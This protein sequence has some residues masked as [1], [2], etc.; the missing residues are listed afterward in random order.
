MVLAGAARDRWAGAASTLSR[1]PAGHCP[2][3]G[4]FALDL[5]GPQK[6]SIQEP[7]RRDPA[8]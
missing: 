1:T 7:T 8:R 4:L 6:L 2:T 5:W 3:G